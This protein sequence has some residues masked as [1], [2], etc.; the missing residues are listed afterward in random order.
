MNRQAAEKIRVVSDLRVRTAQQAT[1]ATNDWLREL[2]GLLD[3]TMR[4]TWLPMGFRS[5][6]VHEL[7]RMRELAERG[8]EGRDSLL[9]TVSRIRGEAEPYKT[10]AKRS[11]AFVCLRNLEAELK[12]CQFVA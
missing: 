11:A 10:F 3:A 6:V 8:G 7:P 5:L 4:E 1:A 2:A 12:A 9:A